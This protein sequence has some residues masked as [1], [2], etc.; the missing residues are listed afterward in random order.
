MITYGGIELNEQG[1]NEPWGVR[2][3]NAFKS[4]IDKIN[5]ITHNNLSGLQGG[6]AGVIPKQF[7]H[8]TLDQLTRIDNALSTIVSDD[9]LTGDGTSGSPLSVDPTKHV[10]AVATLVKDGFLSK[11]DKALINTIVSKLSSVATDST[12]TG[13]G[14]SGSPLSVDPS[15]HSHDDRYFTESEV[16]AKLSNKAEIIH[17]HSWGNITGQ[18]GTLTSVDF[19]TFLGDGSGKRQLMNATNA[20]VPGRVWYAEQ[21]YYS[22]TTAIQYATDNQN[23]ESYRRMKIQ[24]VWGDWERHLGA[25]FDDRY[26][27]ESE[28]DTKLSAKEDSF[29]K[30]SAFNKNFGSTAGTVTEGNDPRLSDDRTPLVHGNDKHSVEYATVGQLTP[31]VGATNTLNVGDGS[32]GWVDSGFVAETDITEFGGT[33]QTKY[34]NKVRIGDLG[35]LFGFQTHTGAELLSVSN[36]TN[37]VSS[38]KVQHPDATADNESATLGQLKLNS[39]A[40]RTD[41]IAVGDT[42]QEAVRSLN[43]TIDIPYTIPMAGWNPTISSPLVIEKGSTLTIYNG[44]IIG[45]GSGLSFNRNDTVISGLPDID[46]SYALSGSYFRNSSEGSIPVTFMRVG[47]IIRWRGGTVNNVIVIEINGTTPERI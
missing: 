43:S 18:Y 28:I 34:G 45:G 22:S 29:T 4:I 31:S 8:V 19:D 38:R 46:R 44:L 40:E 7:Y 20:P 14:T 36:S 25:N 3:L 10:H 30:N 35:G 11:E 39:I 33:I 13:D 9:T 24:G 15:E 27:T 2:E 21:V 5:A 47:T 41:P 17:T 1:D 37:M 26:Y 16:T 32:G 12:L 42:L 23:G 6:N